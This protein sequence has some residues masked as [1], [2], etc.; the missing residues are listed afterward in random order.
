[1]SYFNFENN[2]AFLSN[3]VTAIGLLVFLVWLQAALL[4]IL[5][6]S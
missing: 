6:I 5:F 3:L 4:L 2:N 1:M